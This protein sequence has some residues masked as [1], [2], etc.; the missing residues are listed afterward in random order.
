MQTQTSDAQTQTFNN[1]SSIDKKLFIKMVVDAWETYNKRF[2]KLLD[3]LTDEQLLSE[4]AP[5]RN[6][7]IYLA[8]HL[9]AVHDAMLPLLGFGEKLY[10]QLEQIFL[11]NPDKSGLEMPSINE[12]K[13]YRDDVN[14]KLSVHINQLQP[15]EWFTKHASVSAE[16]FAKE[17]HR[18][19]LNLVINRT[20]HLSYHLGQLAYLVKKSAL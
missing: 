6:T 19:K 5:G 18:N 1:E 17:P 12:L 4:T 2:N 10:P 16:D 13:K 15:G 3:S 14:A 9:V 11:S 20:N 7:G 8:G